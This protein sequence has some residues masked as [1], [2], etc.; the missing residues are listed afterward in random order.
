MTAFLKFWF[1]S[2]KWRI[3]RLTTRLHAPPGG[4]SS[5]SLSTFV[6]GQGRVANS[7][8]TGDCKKRGSLKIGDGTCDAAHLQGLNQRR[9]RGQAVPISSTEIAT[10]LSGI[11]KKPKLQFLRTQKTNI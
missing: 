8:K 3:H 1:G 11:I 5:I 2:G 6:F 10:S 7:W 4:H 9:N